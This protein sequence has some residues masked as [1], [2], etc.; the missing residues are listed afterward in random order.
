M[1][2][3]GVYLIF[4]IYFP[5]SQSSKEVRDKLLQKCLAE[6]VE[7]KYLWK[8]DELKQSESGWICKGMAG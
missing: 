1:H 4:K 7:V 2:L 5:K 3:L 6:G 8:V